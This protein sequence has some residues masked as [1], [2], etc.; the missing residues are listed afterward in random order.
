MSNQ[1][2]YSEYM[3][4]ARN[5]ALKQYVYRAGSY[6]YNWHQEIELLTVL[7]GNVEVCRGGRVSVLGEGDL[8]SI[9]PNVGHA[10]FSPHSD[11]ILLLLHINI[12]SLKA[13]YLN[14][15]SVDIALNSAGQDRTLPVFRQL[16][17]SLADMMLNPLSSAGQRIRYEKEFFTLL[18]TLV[19]C[20]PVTEL[21]RNTLHNKQSQNEVVAELVRI[22]DESYQQKI[23][24]EELGRKAA[25]HPSYVSQIFKSCL[26]INFMDYLIRIR[27][28]E[29]T[30]DLRL[31]DDPITSIALRHGF[32][33][34]K[35]FNQSFRSSFGKTPSEFR[36]QLTPEMRSVDLAFKK[37]YIRR[38]DPEI[39]PLLERIAVGPET[40]CTAPNG[41]QT[42]QRTREGLTHLQMQL[43]S[44][45]ITLDSMISET[46]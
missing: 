42:S 32:P 45:Q 12:E 3:F 17:Q 40:V 24:L 6:H 36:R 21:R 29:A 23:S 15:E 7:K 22:I 27:M 20:F 1:E 18:D 37:Q 19:S 44:L 28:R 10:T 2:Y 16:R 31:C 11:G 34:V 41:F 33:N 43:R 30:K 8:I 13:F 5:L 25:Y 46:S 39:T 14:A 4:P 26:G 35:S 38:D 9:G